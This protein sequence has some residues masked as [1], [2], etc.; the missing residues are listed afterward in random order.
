VLLM[1]LL[2]G[3]FAV[4]IYQLRPVLRS[5][6]PRAALTSVPDTKK[7]VSRPLKSPRGNGR[8]VMPREPARRP[9]KPGRM[10]RKAP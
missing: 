5:R 7:P 8:V 2:G 9:D 6:R 3:V 4:L 1:L 10:G